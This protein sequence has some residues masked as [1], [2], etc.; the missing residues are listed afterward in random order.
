[1]YKLRLNALKNSRNCPE[2]PDANF[3]RIGQKPQVFALFAAQRCLAIEA[4][5]PM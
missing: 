5:P 3:R 2:T 4:L 1:M